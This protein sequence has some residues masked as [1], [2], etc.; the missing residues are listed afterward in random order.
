[1]SEVIPHNRPHLA[2]LSEAVN[3]LRDALRHFFTQRIPKDRLLTIIE[4]NT[5][6]NEEKDRLEECRNSHRDIRDVI[7]I[8]IIFHSR[9]DIIH[10]IPLASSTFDGMRHYRNW[11]CH[12]D[13]ADIPRNKLNRS[14]K[15]ICNILGAI[16]ATSESNAVRLLLEEPF[17]TSHYFEAKCNREKDAASKCKD[18]MIK[19]QDK[20]IQHKDEAIHLLTQN[21]QVLR[22][23]LEAHDIN[24]EPILRS[25]EIEEV[26]SKDKNQ[27]LKKVEKQRDEAIKEWQQAVVALQRTEQERDSAKIQVQHCQR[28][29]IQAK[30]AKEKEGQAFKLKLEALEKKRD[31]AIMEKQQVTAALQRTEQER[32]SAKVQAQ[33]SQQQF[34][35]AK[36]AKEK[37]GQAFKLKQKELEKERDRAIVEKQQVQERIVG[38]QDKKVKLYRRTTFSISVLAFFAVLL[39]FLLNF[40][41]REENTRQMD[42]ANVFQEPTPNSASILSPTVAP[43]LEPSPT[44]SLLPTAIPAIVPTIMPTPMPTA[45]LRPS[46]TVAPTATLTPLPTVSIDEEPE[47]TTEVRMYAGPGI[48][49]EVKGEILQS[50]TTVE[51]LGI[52]S[53]GDWYVLANRYWI[54]APAVRF[55]PDDLAVTSAPYVLTGANLRAEPTTNSPVQ[56]GVSAGSIIVIVGQK[57]GGP[58]AGTWYQLDSGLWIYGELIAG[59]PP[60]LPVLP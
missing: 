11:V 43:N 23:W 51:V 13:Y 33:H 50:G 60:N 24:L 18:E 39:S 14:L 49:F 22:N 25:E 7:D 52:D 35:Q 58:P 10:E 4:S 54:P 56:G 27:E 2:T 59:V 17:T 40:Q 31:R 37:E 1:M 19:Q 38:E 28:Q 5:K 8:N 3:I 34:I 32:D 48:E 55:A 42:T 44:P 41:Q 45:T 29:F 9:M 6:F 16:G 53:S 57:E 36:R 26:K 30:Q 12:P 15:R 20:A 46:P 21:N 47:V